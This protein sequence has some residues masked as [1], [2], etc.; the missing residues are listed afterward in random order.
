M[1]ARQL[2]QEIHAEAER[3]LAGYPTHSVLVLPVVGVPELRD[4]RGASKRGCSKAAVVGKSRMKR[5]CGRQW[6][7]ESNASVIETKLILQ[8]V[9]NNLVVP[10]TTVHRDASKI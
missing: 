4:I 6:E 7:V 10:E 1:L 2:A 3:M 9:V 8:F 5:I